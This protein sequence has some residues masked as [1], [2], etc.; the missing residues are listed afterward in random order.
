M[1]VNWDAADLPSGMSFFPAIAA[2]EKGS[3]VEELNERFADKF[4]YL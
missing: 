1:A 3:K 4:L 2:V